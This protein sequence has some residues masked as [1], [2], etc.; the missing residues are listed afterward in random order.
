M[1]RI[2][3]LAGLVLALPTL[4]LAAPKQKPAAPPNAPP[5]KAAPITDTVYVTRTGKRYHREGCRSLSQSKI[6]MSRSDAEKAGFTPCH[7]CKP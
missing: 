4:G 5:K 3:L 6:P 2:T 7:V 1:K